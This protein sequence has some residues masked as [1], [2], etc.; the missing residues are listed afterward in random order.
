MSKQGG[1]AVVRTIDMQTSKITYSKE[2]CGISVNC[3]AS[4]EV[5][6]LDK[7]DRMI[8]DELGVDGIITETTSRI[9]VRFQGELDHL[10][11]T[12]S[13]QLLAVRQE[14]LIAIN[15]PWYRVLLDRI[16]RQ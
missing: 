3:P 7:L 12:H 6:A 8:V 4:C 16:W 11:D 1:G 2:A 9:S 5:E 10:I 14:L 15:K 13:T